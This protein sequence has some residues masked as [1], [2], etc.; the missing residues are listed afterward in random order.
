MNLAAKILCLITLAL[1]ICGVGQ[2]QVASKDKIE[3]RLAVVS[4]PVHENEEFTVKVEVENLTNRPILVGRQLNLVANFPIR[5]EVELEDPAE[6]KSYPYHAMYVDPPVVPDFE[7]E[8]GFL[9]WWMPL[10]PHNFLGAS[11]KLSAIGRAGEYKLRA[12]YVSHPPSGAEPPKERE[13]DSSRMAVF[14]GTAVSHSVSLTVLPQA[15]K[16]K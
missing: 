3:I 2:G 6:R 9:R 14:D 5:L 1:V 11:F 16:A 15:P 10:A 8:N 12:L 7:M 13:S 4:T